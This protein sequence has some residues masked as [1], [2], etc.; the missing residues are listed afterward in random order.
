MSSDSLLVLRWQQAYETRLNSERIYKI[1]NQI[2][3]L[4][5]NQNK[6]KKKSK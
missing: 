3:E 1:D 2:K 5:Q 4:S 6:W